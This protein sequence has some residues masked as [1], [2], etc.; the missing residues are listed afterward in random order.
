M[1]DIYDDSIVR[2]EILNEALKNRSIKGVELII[3]G[4]ELGRTLLGEERY[5]AT[6]DID[7]MSDQDLSKETIDIINDVGLDNVNVL[8]APPPEDFE[9]A[10]TV[11]FSNLTVYYP[12]IEDFALTKLMTKRARDDEDLIKYPILDNCDI[13]DLKNRIN[14]YKTYMFTV[15]NPEYNFHNLDEYLKQR[16]IEN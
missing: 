15:N 5:R 7:Y 8:D 3:I 4:G 2:Y 12:S 16:N 9:K 13:Q 1:P 14:E 6:I 11:R 10:Y